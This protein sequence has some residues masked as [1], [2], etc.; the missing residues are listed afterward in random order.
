MKAQNNS[1]QEL[2]NILTGGQKQLEWQT[3]LRNLINIKEQFLNRCPE[4]L[5]VHL[6]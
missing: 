2:G 5:A 3:M 6:S 1:S 4:N